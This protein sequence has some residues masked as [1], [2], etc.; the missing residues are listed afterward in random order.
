[1]PDWQAQLPLIRSL[2]LEAMPYWNRIQNYLSRFIR[3]SRV[4]RF[5]VSL[6]F[7]I[8]VVLLYYLLRLIV[9]L[10]F[11]SRE[12]I[13]T[14]AFI[15][16]AVLLLFPA[17]EAILARIL[18]RYDYLTFFGHDLHHLELL[19]R[20]F[21]VEELIHE[22]LPEF[23]DWLGVRESIL[24]VQ[25]PDRNGYN[26]YHSNR[27]HSTSFNP[28][29]EWESDLEILIRQA[30]SHGRHLDALD[31]T[32]SDEI[33]RLLQGMNMAILYPFVYRKGLPGFMILH[34]SPRHPHAHKALQFF[35]HKSAVAIQN[36]LLSLRVID[37]RLYDQEMKTA[38]RIQSIFHKTQ[39]PSI[40]GYEFQP[41]GSG[42]TVIEFFTA[43]EEQHY[44]VALSADRL[45]SAAGI[46]LYGLL[47]RLHALLYNRKDMKI[48]QIMTD[49]KADPDFKREGYRVDVLIAE[50]KPDSPLVTILHSGSHYTL[51]DATDPGQN[52]LSFGWRNLLTLQA[53]HSYVL[54]YHSVPLITI[55]FV[56]FKGAQD[57][58]QTV[59]SDSL[60]E[61]DNHMVTRPKDGSD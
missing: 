58:A 21:S 14:L 6:F 37:S 4:R 46:I 33:R 17:R 35:A 47:G 5:A 52:L 28:P 2:A 48:N 8:L 30:K 16:I 1:M 22:I 44:M 19:A 39:T 13:I 36:Y 10:D 26:Y 56:P 43:R 27:N 12:Q 57:Q 20:Q 51:Y 29:T 53:D 24:A 31:E 45:S 34:Q 15:L 32:W 54:S 38:R 18:P 50:I 59:A 9:P 3:G 11:D 7:G 61:E 25:D 41:R 40:Q 55:R 23:T 60:E 49:L 42:R